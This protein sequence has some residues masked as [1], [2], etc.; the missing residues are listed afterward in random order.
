M[1]SPEL[2]GGAGFTYEDAAAAQNLAAMVASRATSI[3]TRS[4]ADSRTF[5]W[6]GMSSDGY[7]GFAPESGG[8][9]EIRQYF[10]NFLYLR[11]YFEPEK[12]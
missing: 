7:W 2:M 6:A 4:G 11:I 8:K 3:F 10:V 9:G 1:S 12:S 5:L